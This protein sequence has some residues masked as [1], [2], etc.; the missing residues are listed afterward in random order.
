MDLLTFDRLSNFHLW[1][2]ELVEV[3]LVFVILVEVDIAN[4]L[5]A[6]RNAI[7]IGELMKQR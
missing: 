2:L 4:E 6:I 1:N 7:K 5:L 3:H